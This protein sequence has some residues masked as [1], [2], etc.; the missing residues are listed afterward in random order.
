MERKRWLRL[1]GITVLA[2]LM[3]AAWP[4]S[5]L[6]AQEDQEKAAA[7][8]EIVVTATKT[9]R[10]PEDIPASITVIT[11][12]EIKEQNI[13]LLDEALR[14]V[15]GAYDS[16]SKGWPDTMT[17]VTLRG[18]PHQKRTLVLF[19][20]Q[21]MLSAYSGSF[22][23]NSL[24]VEDVERIE[25]VRG[26]FSALYGGNAMGGVI[27]IIPKTPKKLE[28]QGK[29]GYGKYDSWTYYLGAGDRFWDKLSC[30][31]SYNYRYTSGYPSKLVTRSAR[32]GAAAT[33]VHGW[34]YT[35][36][37]TG[38]DSYIIGDKGDNSWSEHIGS[39]RLN[40]D[41]APGHKINFTT[42]L[43]WY[44][45]G[46]SQFET[47]L[48]NIATG[49]PVFSGTVG[50]AGTGLRIRGLREGNFL[51]GDGRAHIATYN[52]HT[53][54]QLT[55]STNL[56]LRAG[57]MS[58]AHSMWTSPGSKATKS[59]GP[60]VLSSTPSKNWSF[61]AQVE[62]GL[63]ISQVLTGG[64]VYK[65]GWAAAKR[66]DL[67]NWR[68][69]V[70]RGEINRQS[71]GRDRNFAFYLQDEIDWH[72]KFSTVIGARL[73]WW[74]TYGGAY[75]EAAGEPII[76]LPCRSKWSFNPKIAFLYRPWEW[77]SW[78]ASAGSA[79]RPP[80]IYELYGTFRT[81][82]GTLYKSNPDLDPETSL[83]WEIGT[84]I[85]PFKGNV[86][87][88]TYFMSFVDDLIYRVIDPTDPTEKTLLNE[89]A[90]TARIRGIE[91]EIT[92]QL[93]SW[94]KVF[95]NMT[96]VDARITDNPLDPESVDKKITFV[97]RQQF[98]FGLNLNYWKVNANLSGRYVSK[99]HTRSDNAD[100]INNVPGSYDPY[101]VLDTKLTVT[102]VQWMDVS[103]AVDNI[104]NRKY[105]RNSVAPSRM[106]WL[107][108]GVK[109]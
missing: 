49:D 43:D 81:S 11:A 64:L 47:Y 44:E 109:Y 104:F 24:P 75:M 19:D 23:W 56:T 16:R 96:L 17:S 108:M 39:L 92:Q 100:I 72:P 28:L 101:F 88:A 42:L 84:T 48:R 57:L 36:K 87:A 25:V 99:V 53:E 95:G 103:F 3:S 67:S 52:L 93:F 34:R 26:P 86:I 74:Q 38:K 35:R 20:G 83:S 62:Q 102:P 27:N 94:L 90:G 2:L 13:K 61:E 68:D 4:V 69:T 97:P 82:G 79:F 1:R 71:G 91:L 73:D 51:G 41:L 8:E 33:Q 15:P 50:L 30:K 37:T 7:L 78:R 21:D 80:S 10:N 9:P 63:G 89:N 29:W 5:G 106:F 55:D 107:E 66:F 22:R 76:N 46:Y 54:H 40:W 58:W 12:K 45:Y 32:P 14:Q 31:I 65:T 60:G 77:M 85:K 6:W 70:S 59:G 98:N 18:F 105:F